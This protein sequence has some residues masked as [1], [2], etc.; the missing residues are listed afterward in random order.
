[1]VYF[2]YS[3]Q[4]SLSNCPWKVSLPRRVSVLLLLL[5]VMVTQ[6]EKEP[7]SPAGVHPH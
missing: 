6:V 5:I 3:A 7:V 4:K 1:M 2:K